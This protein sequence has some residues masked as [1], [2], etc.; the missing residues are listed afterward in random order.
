[1]SCCRFIQRFFALV[2]RV[3]IQ[4]AKAYSPGKSLLT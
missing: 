2:Q 4:L 3:T 1:L